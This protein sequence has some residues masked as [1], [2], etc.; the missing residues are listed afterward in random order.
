VKTVLVNAELNVD[1]INHINQATIVEKLIN[2]EGV[3]EVKAD[4]ASKII[5]VRYDKGKTGLVN[6]KQA[7]MEEGYSVMEV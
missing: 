5:S 4:Y 2:I 7:I 1:Q 3:A 6:I